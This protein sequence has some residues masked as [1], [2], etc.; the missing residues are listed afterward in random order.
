LALSHPP[1]P[2]SGITVGGENVALPPG[3]V[4]SIDT[5]TPLIGGPADAVAAIYAKVPNSRPLDGDFAGFF[6]FPCGTVIKIDICFGGRP[7]PIDP[8]EM[9]LGPITNDP[10]TC[11]GAI[12]DLNAGTK[13]AENNNGGKPNWVIGV[14]FLRN[15]YSVFQSE[16]AA[17]GFAQLA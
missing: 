3:G 7:W 10:A 11:V 12:F 4:A 8:Q 16:P 14:A 9:D 13:R 6:G 5:G 2:I 15:V 17:V 1:A